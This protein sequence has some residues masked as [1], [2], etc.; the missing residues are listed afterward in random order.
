MYKT[1][2]AGTLPVQYLRGVANAVR[3]SSYTVKDTIRSYFVQRECSSQRHWSMWYLT[4]YGALVWCPLYVVTEFLF[5]YL[6]PSDPPSSIRSAI[7][8]LLIVWWIG[9]VAHSVTVSMCAV[10]TICIVRTPTIEASSALVKQRRVF[11]FLMLVALASFLVVTSLIYV[12]VYLRKSCAI[13]VAV[14]ELVGSI[15]ALTATSMT[16]P[17]IAC[18]NST[19]FGGI[20]R[21]VA[22]TCRSPGAFFQPVLSFLL[23]NT[24]WI[25]PLAI[26]YRPPPMVMLPVTWIVASWNMILLVIVFDRLAPEYDKMMAMKSEATQEQL[27]HGPEPSSK[28]RSLC[29]VRRAVTTALALLVYAVYTHVLQSTT[30]SMQ[31]PK[32]WFSEARRDLTGAQSFEMLL[33]NAYAYHHGATYG[34]A[35]VRG[36]FTQHHHKA[37]NLFD[38][39]DSLS[40]K[41][42]LKFACPPGGL[43][44]PSIVWGLLPWIIAKRIVTA[45]WLESLRSQVTYPDKPKDVFKIAVHIR[46]GDISPCTGDKIHKYLPNSFYLDMIDKYVALAALP[47]H[48]HKTVEV[49]IHCM[50]VSFEPLDVFYARNY[51]VKLDKTP[52]EE[53]WTE[54]IMADVFI[55]SQSGFSVVPALLN[56]GGVIVFPPYLFFEAAPG[57]ESVDLRA[58]KR[59]KREAFDFLP[60]CEAQNRTKRYRVGK[61]G[62]WY[63][64][65]NFGIQGFVGFFNPN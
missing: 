52:L 2:Q 32:V 5:Y 56:H 22:V 65:R 55:M 57:W 13:V 3:I 40:V 4:L 64:L 50:S 12:V 25:G 10:R 16:I 61:S 53:V 54:L 51:T 24:L 31:P 45:D 38:R 37:K 30:E 11:T 18:E 47:A 7:G 14:L 1:L 29:T 39:L 6:N 63:L 33:H 35:C 21:S 26:L 46:R 27:M 19:L 15:V 20:V 48:Q 28:K 34:G 44:D 8:T 23:L 36:N 49:V 43:D 62:V 58:M 41:K 17:A 59:Y 60:T 9:A 42:F